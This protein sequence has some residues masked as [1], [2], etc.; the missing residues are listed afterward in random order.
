LALGTRFNRPNLATPPVTFDLATS[1]LTSVQTARQMNPRILF[2]D[3]EANMRELL[4]LYLR[5][6]GMEVTAVA[7]GPQAKELFSQAPFDL[8]I[9][10]LRL[11]GVDSWDVLNFIKHNDSKHPVIIYSGLDENELV[12][13]K[14]F[15]GRADAV[16]RKM[17]PLASL[18]AEIRQHLPKSSSTGEAHSE[19]V[20][21][22]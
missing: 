12:Q 20:P 19:P 4:S 22:S 16:V 17:S 5:H 15:L 14:D 6:E 13:K 10:D 3:D 1:T 21:R 2:V 8:T 11:A 9:L 18:L 7:T